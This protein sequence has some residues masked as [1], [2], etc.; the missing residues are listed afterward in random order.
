M[1]INNIHT[2]IGFL[3]N[4]GQNIYHEPEQIDDAINRASFDLFRQEIKVFEREQI[5]TD[6][7]R[8]FKDR[9]VY[10]SA[11]ASH[12]LPEDYITAT[13]VSHL[14]VNTNERADSDKSTFCDSTLNTE[15]SESPSSNEKEIDIITDSDWVKRMDN[16]IVG[17]TEKSPIA[18]IF[19]NNFEVKPNTV[20]PIL[21]YLKEPVK[22]KWAYTISE[23]GRSYIFDAG[24]S[25]DLEWKQISHSEIIEKTLGYLG[26][27][28]RDQVMMQY[29]QFQK[30]NNNEK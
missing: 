23:D 25:T 26:M 30:G 20:I 28:V 1:L 15:E 21:Y 27:A 19:N 6:T 18:R 10:T 14:Y 8:P 7:L 3:K 5:L 9:K 13:N 2:F 4:Q 16:L 12:D 24:N 22:A 17:P 11:V 29:E